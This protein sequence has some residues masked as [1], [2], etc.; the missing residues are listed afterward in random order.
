LQN[1]P[2]VDVA[3]D[4]M[5]DIIIKDAEINELKKQLSVASVKKAEQEH[6]EPTTESRPGKPAEMIG[7]IREFSAGDMPM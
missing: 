7:G 1:D 3:S 2:G 6:I 4:L 5:V